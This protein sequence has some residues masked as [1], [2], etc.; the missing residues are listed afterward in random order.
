[1]AELELVP[2]DHGNL[3]H[4]I[5]CSKCQGHAHFLIFERVK[6]WKGAFHLQKR[7]AKCA[8]HLQE[9]QIGG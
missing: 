8:N 9:C 6:L 2:I 4:P 3:E 7:D 5:L 1:M